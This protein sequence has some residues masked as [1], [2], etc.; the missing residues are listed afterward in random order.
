MPSPAS[1]GKALEPVNRLAVALAVGVV[2]RRETGGAP[3]R[4]RTPRWPVSGGDAAQ[5]HRKSVVLSLQEDDIG[6][7]LRDVIGPDNMIWDSM[8]WASDHRKRMP[9]NTA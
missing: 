5:R 6:M 9:P 8:M 4:V 1:R 3:R 2:H 7:R